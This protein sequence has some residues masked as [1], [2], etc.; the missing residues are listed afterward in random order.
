MAKRKLRPNDFYASIGH[1]TLCCAHLELGIDLLI[2]LLH[3]YLGGKSVESV[4]PW[5]LNRK[6]EYI[7]RCFRKISVLS[8]YREYACD[9]AAEIAEASEVRHDMIHGVLVSF[10]KTRLNSPL[11]DSC[12]AP[13]NKPTSVS[14]LTPDR[15]YTAQ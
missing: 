4:K 2:W 1:L 14:R 3:D 12:A 11:S 5:A 13:K 7:R 9:L 8:A 10:P 6:L 15:Y